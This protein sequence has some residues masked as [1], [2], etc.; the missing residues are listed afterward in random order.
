MRLSKM[1]EWSRDGRKQRDFF[2]Q[3]DISITHWQY[4]YH[5]NNGFSS[6]SSATSAVA[7]WNR[8]RF[9]RSVGESEATFQFL[10][11]SLSRRATSDVES[12]ITFEF[13]G[14]LIAWFSTRASVT[15]AFAH[16]KSQR[17]KMYRLSVWWT[18]FSL[19]T[20]GPTKFANLLV[21]E[22]LTAVA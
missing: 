9:A 1:S 15:S 10:Y 4:I 5:S 18:I 22:R 19:R 6:I 17:E 8:F 7:T 14:T 3:S 21:Y 2:A 13:G 16:M 20:F 11:I 12:H